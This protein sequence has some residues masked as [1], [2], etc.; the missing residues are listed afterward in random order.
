VAV[1]LAVQPF[2]ILRE[3]AH[4]FTAPS[5]RLASPLYPFATTFMN[6]AGLREHLQR[7]DVLFQ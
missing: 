6:H 3:Y 2:D 1:S 5:V 7:L 4:G